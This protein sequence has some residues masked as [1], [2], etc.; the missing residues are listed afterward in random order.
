[1][2]STDFVVIAISFF[3]GV[4]VTLFSA[5][6]AGRVSSF[7]ERRRRLTQPRVRCRVGLGE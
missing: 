6:L 3:F 7:Y 1:M 2:S 4:G 5:Y